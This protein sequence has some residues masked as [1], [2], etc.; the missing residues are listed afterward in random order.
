MLFI[1]TCHDKPNALDLRMA[2]REKHLAYIST[3]ADVVRLAGPLLAEDGGMVG[4]HFIIEVS[5]R[6]E[7]E[8]FSADDPYTQAGL[9]ERIELM[10]FRAIVGSW[11]T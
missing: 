11:V 10:S 6:A 7:A 1:L 3:H 8:R 5:D 9:F 4:S 2:T